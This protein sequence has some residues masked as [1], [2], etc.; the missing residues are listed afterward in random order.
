[1][2]SVVFHPPLGVVFGVATPERL[3]MFAIAKM[4]KTAAAASK[5]ASTATMKRPGTWRVSHVWK[6][7][8]GSCRTA[9]FE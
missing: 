4:L 6:C 2:F 5:A 9:T 8:G 3:P 7:V 1:M